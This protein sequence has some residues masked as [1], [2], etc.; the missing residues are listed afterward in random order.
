MGCSHVV[1]SVSHRQALGWEDLCL[2]DSCPVQVRELCSV[3]PDELH[4]LPFYARIAA[5]VSS[6]FATVGETMS[7]AAE[8]QFATLKVPPC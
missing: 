6:V 2:S 4:L 5:S 1:Q 8:T 3:R 7:Q